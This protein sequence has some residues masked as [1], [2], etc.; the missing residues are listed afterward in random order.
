[1]LV[2][3]DI[4]EM[5][6]PLGEPVQLTGQAEVADQL[7]NRDDE[8]TLAISG[9]TERERGWSFTAYCGSESWTLNLSLGARTTPRSA[10]R[11]PR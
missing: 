6:L 5:E 2:L 4:A 11:W 1:M 3:P 7:F 9:T 8:L 10:C